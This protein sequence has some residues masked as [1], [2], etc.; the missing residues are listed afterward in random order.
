MI[1]DALNIFSDSQAIT[2]TADST[3][4]V[5]LGGVKIAG[6][7]EPILINIKVVED[8]ATLTSL[9]VEVQQA[10]TEGGSYAT[11]GGGDSGAIPVA[12]LKRGYM[13]PFRFLPR[14]VT[15]PWL[16][17]VYTVAGSNATAGKVMAALVHEEQDSYEAGQFI[18]KGKVVA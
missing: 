1:Y 12:T 2:A 6:K 16:K 13:F 17:L 15:K 11:V 4:K 3:K 10:D 5:H 18:D 14:A 8:F 7:G 9:K